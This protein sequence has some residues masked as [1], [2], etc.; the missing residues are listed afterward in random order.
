VKRLVVAA[1]PLLGVE[2]RTRRLKLDGNGH[3]D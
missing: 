3:D 2:D 1:D